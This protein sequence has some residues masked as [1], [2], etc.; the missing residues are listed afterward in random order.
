MS[1]AGDDMASSQVLKLHRHIFRHPPQIPQRLVWPFGQ[2]PFQAFGSISSKF[3]YKPSASEYRLLMRMKDSLACRK[4]AFA[5]TRATPG[6][7]YSLFPS[8]F[9][10]TE[11]NELLP[12]PPHFS[13]IPNTFGVEKTEIRSKERKHIFLIMRALLD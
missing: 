5:E 6:L 3:M 2:A 9:L 8:I 7:R 4:I 12:R 1:K 10:Q 13:S 11:E